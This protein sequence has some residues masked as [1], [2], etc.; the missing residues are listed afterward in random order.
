MDARKRE[1]VNSVSSENQTIYLRP[2]GLGQK[3]ADI[4]LSEKEIPSI[5]RTIENYRASA[6]DTFY[7]ENTHIDRREKQFLSKHFFLM[8]LQDASFITQGQLILLLADWNTLFRRWYQDHMHDK[9]FYKR[10]A[11]EIGKTADQQRSY[12]LREALA[13]VEDDDLRQK[14]GR[15]LEAL[16]EAAQSRNV[17]DLESELLIM[18]PVGDSLKNDVVSLFSDFPNSLDIQ[19]IQGYAS[20]KLNIDDEYY[21][22]LVDKLNPDTSE[23]AK[24]IYNALIDKIILYY[25]EPINKYDTLI[26][27]WNISNLPELCDQ[28]KIFFFQEIL[29]T[30]ITRETE[31][32]YILKEAGRYRCD[33]NNE[34]LLHAQDDMERVVKLKTLIQNYHSWKDSWKDISVSDEELTGRCEYQS[35]MYHEEDVCPLLS[36]DQI[37]RVC[38][39]T[40]D[41]FSEVNYRYHSEVRNNLIRSTVLHIIL[42]DKTVDCCRRRPRK[43]LD[44]VP[45][46][47]LMVCVTGR[48]LFSKG[49]TMDYD[50]FCD[51]L[52]SKSTYDLRPSKAVQR[53]AR[54][55]LLH[56]L[57][58]I[59]DLSKEA[60]MLN[61]F[62]FLSIHG[63]E[64]LS[65]EELQLWRDITL[66]LP[67]IV[68]IELPILVSDCLAQCLPPMENELLS[69][70]A[71]SVIHRGGG[72][73]YLRQHADVTGFVVQLISKGIQGKAQYW[74]KIAHNYFK[75]AFSY[76][77]R[78][79]VVRN[80]LIR[81]T[82]LSRFEWETIPGA[83]H[84]EMKTYCHSLYE[85]KKQPERI[86]S[87]IIELRSLIVETALREYVAIQCKK[88]L[89]A[90]LDKNGLPYVKYD[91]Y[92]KEHTH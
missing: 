63:S 90:A 92:E 65:V 83:S 85:G 68:P 59:C 24:Q 67:D 87:N 26:K 23:Y 84:D 78:P 2:H 33:Y 56:H 75:E 41:Y 18:F 5:C 9:P 55:R 1:V 10:L 52:S 13:C 66:Q 50:K 80:M 7:L 76:S 30:Y 79:S 8:N 29:Y 15:C 27:S 14:Y 69:Y 60:Q 57:N 45:L 77:Y 35:N 36:D 22:S 20:K 62:R 46:V 28:E 21:E 91:A 39:V 61:W 64:I 72:I 6:I 37:T 81:A 3:Q 71:G 49:C 54:I 88:K 31:V 51:R 44:D 82:K 86:E 17:A 12:L 4:S 25:F 74:D 58:S 38:E 34:Y 53:R 48:N 19:E 43:T 73:K 11:Q 40:Q 89:V 70:H 32:P 16:L 47:F 42:G